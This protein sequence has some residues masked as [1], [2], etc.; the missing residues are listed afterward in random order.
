MT[1]AACAK[2]PELPWIAEPQD[3]L[4]YP[5]RV[6]AR[7][8]ATCP[9]LPECDQFASRSTVTAGFWA[10]RSRNERERL[11]WPDMA[12]ASTIRPA[13]SQPAS[14]AGAAANVATV[15]APQLRAAAAQ[16]TTGQDA[17]GRVED[18]AN[19]PARGAG[20]PH[21]HD[22]PPNWQNTVARRVPSPARANGRSPSLVQLAAAV[23]EALYRYETAVRAQRGVSGCRVALYAAVEDLYRYAKT[24][25]SDKPA[26][27]RRQGVA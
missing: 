10:G 21:D 16:H 17:H 2:R 18:H 23:H 25:A 5:R 8:C 6:M 13:A 22:A 26:S 1:F 19:R 7:V 11:P 15:L 9:V 27:P 20:Q 4:G 3:T 12:P 14:T 24:R